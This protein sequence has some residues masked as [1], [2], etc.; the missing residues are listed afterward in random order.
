MSLQAEVTPPGYGTMWALT[1]WTTPSLRGLVHEIKRCRVSRRLNIDSWIVAESAVKSVWDCLGEELAELKGAAL[2]LLVDV[3]CGPVVTHGHQ[4]W[5][6]TKRTRS[7]SQTEEMDFLL[8][9]REAQTVLRRPVAPSCRVASVEAARAFCTT[10]SVSIF[11]TLT[12]SWAGFNLL[13]DN[14]M[15]FNLSVNWVQCQLVLVICRLGLNKMCFSITEKRMI[16]IF[17]LFLEKYSDQS[18]FFWQMYWSLLHLLIYCLIEVGKVSS[19][20]NA[21][22]DLQALPR[23]CKCFFYI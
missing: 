11:S 18:L 16:Q 19:P 12:Y 13:L 14:T 21:V 20:W 9:V 5:V 6:M 15:A 22:S 2:H 17:G 8:R 7:G 3:L 1:R 10:C 4:L 23:A